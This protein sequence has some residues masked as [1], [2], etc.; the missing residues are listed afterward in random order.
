MKT[1]LPKKV[2]DAICFWSHNTFLNESFCFNV[3]DYFITVHPLIGSDYDVYSSIR[4]WRSDSLI[5][6]KWI[7]LSLLK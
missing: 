3:D 4:V 2:W 7:K 5:Y 6:Q 1:T